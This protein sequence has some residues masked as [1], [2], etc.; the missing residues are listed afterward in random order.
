MENKVFMPAGTPTCQAKGCK[1]YALRAEIRKVNQYAMA[2]RP[3]CSKHLN[4]KKAASIESFSSVIASLRNE[5]KR[6]RA[7]NDIEQANRETKEAERF[8]D[9]VLELA[10]R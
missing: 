1:E 5:A 9:R 3:K 8:I 7:L 2:Y 6:Q 4:L 10:L